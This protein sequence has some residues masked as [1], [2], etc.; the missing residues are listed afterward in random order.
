MDECSKS[1]RGKLVE[2]NLTMIFAYDTEICGESR[3]QAEESRMMQVG[4]CSGEKRNR[5]Q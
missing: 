5:S 2:N 1:V 3:E 4:E